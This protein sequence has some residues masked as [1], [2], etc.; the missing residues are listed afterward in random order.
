LN[1]LEIHYI[2]KSGYNNIGQDFLEELGP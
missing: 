1:S 2:Q